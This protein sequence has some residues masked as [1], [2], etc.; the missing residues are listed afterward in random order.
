MQLG[1]LLIF[2][3]LLLLLSWH[4]DGRKKIILRNLGL[5]TGAIGILII[6]IGLLLYFGTG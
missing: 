4:T 5:I 3:G 2:A 6:V 1:I